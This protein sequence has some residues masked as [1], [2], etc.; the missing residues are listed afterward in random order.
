MNAGALHGTEMAQLYST[1][2]ENPR[3]IGLAIRRTSGQCASPKSSTFIWTHTMSRGIRPTWAIETLCQQKALACAREDRVIATV[4]AQVLR[5]NTL[6]VMRHG[7][8]DLVALIMLSKRPAQGLEAF[9][10]GLLGT[11]S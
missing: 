10:A 9:P 3:V 6:P 4:Y 1:T 11:S 7:T 5:R 2:R 8:I